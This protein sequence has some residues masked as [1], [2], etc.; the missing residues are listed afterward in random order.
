MKKI[1]TIA[2]GLITSLALTSNISAQT[3]VKLKLN[4]KA[5]SNTFAKNTKVA[6]NLGDD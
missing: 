5:G 3:A 2:L 6:N 1:Y 4:H